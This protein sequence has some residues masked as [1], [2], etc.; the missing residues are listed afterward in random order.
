MLASVDYISISD[1]VV[2]ILYIL[3]SIA[4][5]EVNSCH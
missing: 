2:T 5:L 4:L 1:R 3:T